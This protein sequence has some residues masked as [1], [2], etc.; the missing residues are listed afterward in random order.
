MAH[1][2]QTTGGRI[3]W[4]YKL[5]L[6]RMET[7]ED[8]ETHILR[9]RLIFERLDSLITSEKPLL[10][11]DLFAAALIIS[12]T[13]DLL[14]FVW[15]LMSPSSSSSED[16]ISTL[17]QDHAFAKT[18]RDTDSPGVSVS[19]ASTRGQHR[20]TQKS[21][22]PFNASKHCDFCD[23][24]G[25]DLSICNTARRVLKAHK[26]G[27]RPSSHPYNS[28]TT[29]AGRVETVSLVN[30]VNNNDDC[31]DGESAIILA[32]SAHIHVQPSPPAV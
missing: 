24:D 31:S 27:S 8:I 25:H 1:E 9:M 28:R 11:D 23:R 22:P 17:T 32:K 10:P 29:K 14:N 7:G 21:T 18:R 13:P 26:D 3:H 15:P 19:K 30:S 4:L 16:V 12:L 5:L 2:D 20:Q 6:T